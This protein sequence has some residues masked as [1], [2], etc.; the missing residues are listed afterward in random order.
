MFY[1][2]ESLKKKAKKNKEAL[3]DCIEHT[4]SIEIHYQEEG[5]KPLLSKVHFPFD[6]PVSMCVYVSMCVCVCVCVYVC[7]CIDQTF[8]L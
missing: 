7:K 1:W 3:N 5:C 8:C 6:D 2:L 4:R